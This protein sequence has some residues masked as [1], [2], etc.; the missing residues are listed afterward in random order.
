MPVGIEW[1]RYNNKAYRFLGQINFSEIR[2]IETEL[3]KSGL[4]S[5]FF[6]DYSED[7]DYLEA[8][9]EGYIH[10]IFTPKL[11]KLQTIE[12]S[13]VTHGNEAVIEFSP[14]VDIPYDEYQVKDWPLD[15]DETMIYDEIREYIHKG[16]D[17][18]LGYPSHRTLADD[19]Y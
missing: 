11:N 8:W 17:Y 2:G 15:E 13:N 10:A 4:L 5:F 1:P 6:D 3:P 12:E 9:E 18:L 7:D 14:T 19:F 16:D